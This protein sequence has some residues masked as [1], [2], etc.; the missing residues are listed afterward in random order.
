VAVSEGVV[1]AGRDHG[2]PDLLG[3]VLVDAGAEDDV[4]VGVSGLADDLGGLGG[5][6]QGEVGAAGNREEK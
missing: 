2:H 4:G 5:L 6:D 1:E 3:H